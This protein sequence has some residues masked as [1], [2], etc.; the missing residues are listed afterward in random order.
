M[1]DGVCWVFLR[2]E[3]QL[4]QQGAM[5]WLHPLVIFLLILTL[6]A[7]AVGNEPT[8]LARLAVPVVWIGALLSLV[9]GMDGLFKDDF[10]SGVLAQVVS[11][12]A[13]LPLW[14]LLRLCVHWLFGA[15]MVALLSLLATPLFGLSLADSVMLGVSVLV[16]SPMLLMLGAIASALTLTAKNGAVLLP[17]IALPL[18]LPVLIFAVGAVERFMMGLNFLPVLALLLAGSILTLIVAPW[19]IAWCLKMAQQG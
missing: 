5:S 14:V 8:L 17:L 7:L 2:R 6:F 13:G 3:W 11:V 1:T 15:G 16:G 12:G 10:D 4:K 19:V 18:Q 9:I